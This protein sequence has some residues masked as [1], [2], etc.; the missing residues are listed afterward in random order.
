MAARKILQLDEDSRS[1]LQRIVKRSSDWRERERAQTLLLLDSG[2]FAQAVADQ[3]GLKVRTV[4]TTH[5]R[6]RQN[7]LASLPDKPRSGAPQK[8]DSGHVQRLVQW[9]KDEPLTATAL[10]ARHLDNGGPS[11]HVNTLVSKLKASGLVWKRTRH[12]LKKAAMKTL[13]AKQP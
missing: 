6:W 13:S 11:V 9:A 10:L 8:L 2:L 1:Q 5:I 3:L 7:A 4:R 12:S